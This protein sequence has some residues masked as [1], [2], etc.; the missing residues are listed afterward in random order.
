MV[1]DGEVLAAFSGYSALIGVLDMIYMVGTATYAEH[2]KDF[3]ELFPD[4]GMRSF[5]RKT[6][7]YMQDM[8]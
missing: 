1:S 4:P 8:F 3:E 5:M 6:A 2:I 7:R